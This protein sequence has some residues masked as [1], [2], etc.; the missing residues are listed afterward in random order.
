LSWTRLADH[1]RLS[2]RHLLRMQQLAEIPDPVAEMVRS[3]RISPSHVYQLARVA[4]PAAQ[5]RLAREAVESGWSVQGL[6][7]R[8]DE[9]RGAASAPAAAGGF[10]RGGDSGAGTGAGGGRG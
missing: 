8:I 2:R 10:A 4:D 9:E 6:R 3:R 5:T 7:R 1:V